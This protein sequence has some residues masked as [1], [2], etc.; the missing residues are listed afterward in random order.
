METK[1]EPMDSVTIDALAAFPDV[2]EAHYDAVPSGFKAWV[3]A[4]WEGM[5]S[6]RLSAI[7]QICHL[8]DIEIE[9]YHVRL[10]RT[11]SESNPILPSLD[12]ES[13]ARE[14]SYAS[15]DSGTVFAGFR[16]ARAE[17]VALIRNLDA[18]QL[19][20]TGQFAE[21]GIVSLRSLVHF[22]CSHDQQ[23]LAGLQWLLAKLAA[24]DDGSLLRS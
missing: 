16:S 8:R 9:G 19:A 14:R 10:R 7:A 20:R 15:A 22:L 21:Y 11:L 1:R 6:E 18:V 13:L 12:S 24:R 17:T 5:P 4:S 23:H 2:L 3:P